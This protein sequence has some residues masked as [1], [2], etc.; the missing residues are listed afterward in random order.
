[1]FDN[2]FNKTYPS[3]SETKSFSVRELL[4]IID[5]PLF[6]AGQLG[7]NRFLNDFITSPIVYTAITRITDNIA[8]INPKM[9]DKK[10]NEFLLTHPLTDLINKNPNPFEDGSEFKVAI[11]S[12][13]LLAGNSYINV[14][15]QLGDIKAKRPPLE[16][17]SFNPGDIS[18]LSTS[19]LNQGFVTQYQYNTNGQSILYTY[20]IL[21]QKYLDEKGN[22]LL[23][24]KTFNP[25]RNANNF[26]GI[27]GLQPVNLEV[28]QYLQA[29]IHNLSVIKNQGRPSAIVTSD[30]AEGGGLAFNPE[31]LTEIKERF[32]E[33]KGAQNAG[34]INFLPF[35]LKWQAIS[36]SVK[37]MDFDK[38]KNATEQA[39][40]KAFKIP[41]TFASNE[42]GTFNN[43]ETDKL[44]LYD[45]AIMP[46]A[47][48]MYNFIGNKLIPR[49]P[50]SENLELCIDESEISVLAE[51][52]LNIALKK[53]KLNVFSDNEIRRDVGEESYGPEGNLIYK[54][55]NLVPVGTDQFTSDN[56]ETPAKKKERDIAYEKACEKA[57]F[58]DMLIKQGHS[59]E[60]IDKVIKEHYE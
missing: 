21:T 12:F 19:S 29:S 41:L 60:H 55:T 48:R 3:S 7:L 25:R 58:R 42:A 45:D 16:Q 15:A 27:S 26:L 34:K 33:I 8:P 4:D 10:K 1:M 22:E 6:N 51:R 56:R 50:N 47:R 2:L 5:I 31:Q 44:S 57:Y 37:D 28:E 52:K 20:D 46:L 18:P 54:P 40:Y 43:K 59:K 14:V 36:E 49:Y 53:V 13:Y 32:T 38:L 11:A 9:F 24:L 23:H 39:V 35:N 30:K 17:Q